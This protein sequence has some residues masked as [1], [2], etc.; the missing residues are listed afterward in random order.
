MP[1]L[2]S[3]MPR[4]GLN[5]RQVE[6]VEKLFDAGRSLLEESAYDELTIRIIAARAGL[7]VATAYT[8]FS[9]KDHLFATLFW[10]HVAS[11]EPP[12][13]S[14]DVVTQLQQTVHYLA[15]V[16]AGSPTLAAAATKSML[17]NDPDVERLRLIIGR[18]WARLFAAALGGAVDEAVLRALT[19]A[20]SGALLEAGVGIVEYVDLGVQLE[21]TFAV[22]VHGNI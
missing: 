14:G 15:D 9:S 10:R 21:S 7:S 22:I 5:A 8:Y 6:T 13:F 12:T 17:A 4:R 19:F 11:A 2:A 1:T 20:F 3:L 16:I 18:H